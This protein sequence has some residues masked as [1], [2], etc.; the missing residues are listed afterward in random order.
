MGLCTP[1]CNWLLDLYKTQSVQVNN[2]S[3]SV[4]SLNTGSPQGCV[5]IPLLFTLM[6]ND[7]H[8]KFGTNHILKFAD[9]T[10]VVG[11]I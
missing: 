11:L 4:I 9:N 8:P 2:N 7:C 10:T 6:T 5:L 1:L 3:S